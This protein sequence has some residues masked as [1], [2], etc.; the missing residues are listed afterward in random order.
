MQILDQSGTME[1]QANEIGS[2]TIYPINPVIY[3]P[4]TTL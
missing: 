2:T 4:L 1:S 3:L